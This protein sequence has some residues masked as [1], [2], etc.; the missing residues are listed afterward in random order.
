[1]HVKT[2]KNW[3]DNCCMKV[4]NRQISFWRVFA[5]LKRDNM[6]IKGK[7]CYL[8]LFLFFFLP[9]DCHL[10]GNL[11]FDCFVIES[12]ANLVSKAPLQR[13]FF[14]N[15]CLTFLCMFRWNAF[16]FIY[17]NYEKKH[18]FWLTFNN[19]MQRYFDLACRE[20]SYHIETARLFLCIWFNFINLVTSIF[21]WLL[22]HFS[23]IHLWKKRP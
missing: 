4:Q 22:F 19:K 11:N 12:R 1:M 20:S 10:F 3:I 5:P 9:S 2:N 6:L 13:A 7:N 23:C 15:C 8:L 18:K 17:K 21:M 14:S 16:S